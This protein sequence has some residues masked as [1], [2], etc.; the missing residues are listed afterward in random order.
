MHLLALSLKYEPGMHFNY[1]S[2]NTNILSYIIRQTVGEKDYPAFPY[3]NLF[4]YKD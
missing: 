2:G 3:T 1:S 4:F